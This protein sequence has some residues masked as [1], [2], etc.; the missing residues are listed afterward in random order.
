MPDKRKSSK[1]SVKKSQKKTVEPII[2]QIV[3]VPELQTTQAEPQNTQVRYSASGRNP[4]CPKCDSF[5]CVCT[6]RGATEAAF[7]CRECE[8]RFLVS[9]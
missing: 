1:K 4:H 9:R 7:R 5:P 2:E 3:S 8:H 6:Y